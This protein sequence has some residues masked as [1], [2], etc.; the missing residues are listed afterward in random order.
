MIDN[1]CSEIIGQWRFR[2]EAINKMN[3]I[4]D[5]TKIIERGGILCGT[6]D[7]NG[8]KK[9]DLVSE[10]KG[11]RCDLLINLSNVCK[12]QTLGI[13]HTHPGKIIQTLPS[14]ADLG[15]HET[16]GWLLTCIGAPKAKIDKII[17]IRS[18]HLS[19]EEEIDKR[20]KMDNTYRLETKFKRLPFHVAKKAREDY[21]N[22]F[23]DI[24][25]EKYYYKFILLNVLK[26]VFNN[27]Y[28]Q[29]FFRSVNLA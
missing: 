13:F 26:T 3:Q 4:T 12:E 1:S 8:E 28:I 17:C 15:Y 21:N 7:K 27:T 20:N 16:S 10:C 11:T 23:K 14:I 19:R 25:S 24:F 18:K 22:Q 9:I 6:T 5:K 29:I 2:K